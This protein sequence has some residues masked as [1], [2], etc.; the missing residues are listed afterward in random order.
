MT[1]IFASA[2]AVI[3]PATANQRRSGA[4]SFTADVYSGQPMSPRVTGANTGGAPIVI[5][6]ATVRVFRHG[7][8]T[9]VLYAHNRMDPVGHTTRVDLLADRITA[10]GVLSVPGASRDRIVGGAE[11]G[12]R[13]AVSVGF[14]A[15]ELEFLSPTKEVTINRRRIKGPAYIAR[16]GKLFEIS[17]LTIG[18]DPA[19]SAK[20]D[21]A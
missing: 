13:W 15:E 7:H 9:P 12:Y 5:D 11:S 4:R 1:F 20:V 18:A 19:A 14:Q 8:K 2:P 16:N 6:I 10:T 21:R 17:L 3:K